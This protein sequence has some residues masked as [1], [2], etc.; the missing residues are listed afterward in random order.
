M[1]L[2]VSGRGRTSKTFSRVLDLCG[3]VDVF[4]LS[5]MMCSG[6]Y[7]Y[8]RSSVNLERVEMLFRWLIVFSCNPWPRSALM[9]VHLI[10]VPACCLSV[11]R[12]LLWLKAPLFFT[13]IAGFSRVDFSFPL[14]VSHAAGWHASASWDG[15]L[16][17]AWRPAG[18][19]TNRVT[20]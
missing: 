20:R 4:S 6:V 18:A 11:G 16:V 7:V 15:L 19:S 5:V 10:C 13:K 12:C 3:F 14:A 8:V 1:L 2:P 17:S 9:R